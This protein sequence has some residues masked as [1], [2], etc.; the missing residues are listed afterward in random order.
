MPQAALRET[1]PCRRTRSLCR[2]AHRRSVSSRRT[3]R[4]PGVVGAACPACRSSRTSRSHKAGRGRRSW[5]DGTLDERRPG[6]A[7]HLEAVGHRER[8]VGERES[9][10]GSRER[11]RSQKARADAERASS[12][13][14]DRHGQKPKTSHGP[15]RRTKSHRTRATDKDHGQ[16]PRTRSDQSILPRARQSRNVRLDESVEVGPGTVK[17]ARGGIGASR[18]GG[19]RRCARAARFAY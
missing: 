2:S 17:E 11:E 9:G 10:L 8:L 12:R 7:L 18:G 5:H 13:G 16:G 15:K 4:E 19:A 14:C 3:I 1:S 6:N